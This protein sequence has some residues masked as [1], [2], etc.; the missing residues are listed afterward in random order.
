MVACRRAPGTGVIATSLVAAAVLLAPRVPALV[1]D[2]TRTEQVVLG[3][4][5]AFALWIVLLVLLSD[6]T[7]LSWLG[8]QSRFV[9]GVTLAVPVLLVLLVPAL[10]PASRLIDQLLGLV[11]V[12]LAAGAVYGVVQYAGLDP[13]PWAVG[14]AA[15]IVIG[16]LRLEDRR[17]QGWFLAAVRAGGV[18]AGSAAVAVGA[19][20]GDGN[21]IARVS[22][23]RTA[24]RMW[25]DAPVT[26]QG[27]GRFESNYRTFRAPDEVT[28]LGAT[29]RDL[30]V[31]TAHHLLFDLAAN[32]G[33]PAVL[34]WLTVLVGTG[35]LLRHGWVSGDGP[36]QVRFLAL[37]AAMGAYTVQSAIS[38]PIITTVYLGWLLIGLTVAASM[39]ARREREQRG[40]RSKG[41]GAKA[42][43]RRGS[44]RGRTGGR[45]AATSRAD[46]AAGV[47][48][49]V[50]AVGVA[51]PAYDVWLTTNDLGRGR[52]A[53]SQQRPDIGLALATSATERTGW[54]PETWHLASEAAR[55]AG[56][57]GQ[58][59]FA[60]EQ[61]IS[62]DPLDRPG[63]FLQ[64]EVLQPDEMDA[65]GELLAE[66]RALDPDG[67]DLHLDVLRF[68]RAVDDDAL[69]RE[70]AD[71]VAQ[72]IDEDHP[73]WEQLK[74]LRAG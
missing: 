63:R 10:T 19:A 73:R 20:I 42:G 44:G 47:L 41:K 29:E 40:R 9:G 34:L 21:G 67:L 54:W 74:A 72:V 61:A 14:G 15:V 7:A 33:T 30:P 26:G 59:L 48:A 53:V 16:L 27:V 4:S 70:V 1:R 38:L 52:S 28:A 11:A 60:A 57:D 35:L 13:M 25:A 24:T 8:V 68:A 39:A 51:V 62:A 18:V 45:R 69:A 58:A 23:W 37:A 2:S 46:I 5:A 49:L 50:A 22:F 36:E 55:A 65:V 32:A 17:W 12:V 64:I 56:D 3:A 6:V 31:D 66:L 43:G 71:I